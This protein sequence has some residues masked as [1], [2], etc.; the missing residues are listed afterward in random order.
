MK[1]HKDSEVH[2]HFMRY[3]FVKDYMVWTYHEEKD[4]DASG[5]NLTSS[6]AEHV[7]R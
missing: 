2:F 3:G 6:T 4:V 5:G 1:A 7:G